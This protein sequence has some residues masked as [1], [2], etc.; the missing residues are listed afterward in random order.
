[1]SISQQKGRAHPRAES[2]RPHIGA[3]G[4]CLGRKRPGLV[5]RGAGSGEMSNALETTMLPGIKA[6][7]RRPA[8]LGRRDCATPRVFATKLLIGGA[9]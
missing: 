9:P 3:D 8:P 2:K 5:I 6:G 4:R 1:M 7:P